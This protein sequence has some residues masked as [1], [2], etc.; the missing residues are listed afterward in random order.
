M[1]LIWGDGSAGYSIAE[2]DTFVRVVCSSITL[3]EDHTQTHTKLNITQVR[4]G[5]P[6]IAVIGNDACWTQI[7]REQQP[8]LGDDVACQLSY[9]EYDVVA[10]GYGGEGYSVRDI[11]NVKNVLVQALKTAR[12]K[13]IPVC[14]NALIGSTDFR[15]GSISV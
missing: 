12:E 8:M 9:T 2:F 11:K 15:E 14:V 4:H 5:L 6:V 13:K 7:L 1:W 10:K 3:L